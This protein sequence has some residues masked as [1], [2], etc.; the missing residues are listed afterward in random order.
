[1]KTYVH[2]ESFLGEPRVEQKVIMAESKLV[3]Y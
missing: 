2:L 3:R 1:M